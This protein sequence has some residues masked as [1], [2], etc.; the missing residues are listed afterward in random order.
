MIAVGMKDGTLRIYFYEDQKAL[1]LDYWW[2]KIAKGEITDIKFSPDN[3]KLICASVDK[4]LYLF[5][6]TKG[7]LT[8]K[9]KPKRFGISKA[10]VKH[11]D[12]S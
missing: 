3:E 4:Y 8:H 5:D 2:R 7:E 12:W 10:W 9:T 6:F 11:V 1:Y